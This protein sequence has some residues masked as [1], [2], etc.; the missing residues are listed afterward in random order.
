MRYLCFIGLV[1][2]WSEKGLFLNCWR[3][4]LEWLLRRCHSM[5]RWIHSS[6][7]WGHWRRWHSIIRILTPTLRRRWWI[8]LSSLR[9]R[10]HILRR[11]WKVVLL[12]LPIIVH[13]RWW[14]II[15]RLI[16]C[17]RR[18]HVVCITSTIA[19]GMVMTT[20]TVLSYLGRCTAWTCY[21][22]FV[23]FLSC[24]I[25]LHCFCQ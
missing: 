3:N 10:H 15:V 9:W 19:M 11:W 2:I 16:T 8:V 14:L 20:S 25:Q 7:Y 18:L 24:I 1:L 22:S 6:H 13:L 5:R 17:R 12:L 21:S 23:L 4:H